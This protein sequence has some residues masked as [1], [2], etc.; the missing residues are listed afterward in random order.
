MNEK[1]QN[2][3]DHKN[4]IHKQTEIIN[5]SLIDQSH[6][7]DDELLNRLS[8]DC[9]KNKIQRAR[10]RWFG[11][12][13]W[14]EESDW[15]KKCTSVAYHRVLTRFGEGF[16]PVATRLLQRASWKGHRSVS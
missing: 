9:V 12:A 4:T 16:G 11:H 7:I 2:I 1:K 14:K 13:E 6:A 15:V 3:I 10:L 8:I 5:S